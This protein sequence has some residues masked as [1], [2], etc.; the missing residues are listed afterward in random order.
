MSG[1][2]SLTS[3]ATAASPVG[4]YTITAALGTLTSQNYTFTFHTGTLTVTPEVISVASSQTMDS[5]VTSGNVQAVVEPSGQLTVNSPVDF[6]SGGAVSVLS[7]GLLAVP[8]LDLGSPP[9]TLSLDGGTLQADNSFQTTVP[10]T[11][12]AG[13]GTV[14]TNGF[15]VTLAAA[16][17]PGTG[18]GGLSKIGSGSLTLSG[19]NSYSG[20]TS[21]SA[22]TLVATTGDALP[23]GGSLTISGG[24]G[25]VLDSL[26]DSGQQM[27]SAAR[28]ANAVPAA[29]LVVQP[30]APPPPRRPASSRCRFGWH[31]RLASARRKHWRHASATRN[32]W[33]LASATRKHWRHASATRA[34][35]CIWA[36]PQSLYAAVGWS[37]ATVGRPHNGRGRPRRPASNRLP[38][39]VALASRQCSPKVL[40]TRQCHPTHGETPAPTRCVRGLRLGLAANRF[41][42]RSRGASATGAGGAEPGTACRNDRGGPN[43]PGG[44]CTA[45]I[46][47]RRAPGCRH[48]MVGRSDGL[49]SDAADQSG[50]ATAADSLNRLLA[51]TWRP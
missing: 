35:S 41:T 4:N 9:A 28:T 44:R 27:G 7:G 29:S 19:E 3:D 13:G 45:A 16:I 17:T 10:V 2:P 34:A 21:I 20:G 46:E 26:L 11:I 15:N 38:I 1:V 43:C 18:S 23:A 39:W 33:R 36:S 47:S 51:S 5:L 31:W 22:G 24:G 49:G 32:H 25:V 30:A 12:Q 6:E 42:Q 14:D 48:P 40:A 37:S 50:P 8:G